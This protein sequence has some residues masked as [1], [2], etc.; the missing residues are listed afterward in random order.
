[1]AAPP[2]AEGSER[3]SLDEQPPRLGWR[4]IYAIVLG[5]LAVQVVVY[6]VLTLVMR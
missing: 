2:D 5:A 6:S 4:R 3:A 1:M